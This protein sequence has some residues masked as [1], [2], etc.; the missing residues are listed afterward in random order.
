MKLIKKIFNKEPK[1]VDPK[2]YFKLAFKRPRNFF[3]LSWRE[4][5]EI[6]E[7]IGI[8]PGTF[9]YGGFDW[10]NWNNHFGFNKEPKIANY[11]TEM[12]DYG[13]ILSI[14]EYLEDSIYGDLDGSAY[15][16]K[17]GFYDPLIDLHRSRPKEIPI[18]CTNVAW[19]NK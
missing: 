18:D 19:F 16:L 6:D 8:P 3:D 2:V 13:D 17:D 11:T 7:K 14:D 10:D 15:P 1:W 12:P 5:A 4:R 9:V